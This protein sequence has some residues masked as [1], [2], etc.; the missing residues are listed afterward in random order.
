MIKTIKRWLDRLLWVRVRFQVNGLT[1]TVVV[2][3]FG[4]AKPR[5]EIV[6]SLRGRPM[7]KVPRRDV[8][9]WN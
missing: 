6:L 5:L 3:R 1:Y 9:R 2:H 8:W 4:L 7:V